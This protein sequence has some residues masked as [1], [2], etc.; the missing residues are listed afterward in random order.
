[1]ISA[2]LNEC[3]RIANKRFSKASAYKRRSYIVYV[4]TFHQREKPPSGGKGKELG[5]RGGG[6]STTCYLHTL[7]ALR[8]TITIART[9][10]RM[11]MSQRA[12]IWI[13]VS[14]ISLNN[15]R[16]I[17]IT[18][19]L[20]D[21]TGRDS[22]TAKTVVANLANTAVLISLIVNLEFRSINLHESWDLGFLLE[23][24]CA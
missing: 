7:Q 5:K 10:M 19:D 9:T 22:P 13:C 3:N 20:R 14:T 2:Q 11:Q 15:N 24:L 17:T 6:L 23:T 4:S 16:R 12:L 8:E 21:L 18:R 1:M